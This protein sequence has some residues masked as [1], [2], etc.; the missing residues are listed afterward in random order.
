MYAKIK[1]KYVRFVDNSF[2]PE[3]VYDFITCVLIYLFLL[4]LNA[5]NIPKPYVLRTQYTQPEQ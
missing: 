5:F 3:N 1:N 2:C 4:T